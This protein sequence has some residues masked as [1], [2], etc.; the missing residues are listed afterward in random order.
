MQVLPE[1][2]RSLNFEFLKAQVIIE[3]KSANEE[4]IDQDITN[5][6]QLGTNILQKWLMEHQ[7]KKDTKTSHIIL[8]QQKVSSNVCGKLKTTVLAVMAINRM[9]KLVAQN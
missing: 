3:R 2:I 7:I 4:E 5:C 9:I 8:T 6:V 1:L